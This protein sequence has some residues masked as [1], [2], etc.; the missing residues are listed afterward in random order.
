MTHEASY[1]PLLLAITLCLGVGVLS[2]AAAA[3]TIDHAGFFSRLENSCEGA[4]RR[5]REVAVKPCASGRNRSKERACRNRARRDY[6]RCRRNFAPRCERAQAQWL[7]DLSQTLSNATTSA[8]DA[9]RIFQACVN[10][11]AQDDSINQQLVRHCVRVE[12]NKAQAGGRPAM[13]ARPLIHIQCDP[14][15]RCPD[16]HSRIEALHHMM[17]CG[18]AS[19]DEDR[20]GD[21]CESVDYD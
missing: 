4:C 7:G 5:D 1:L 20:D 18:L 14:A 10:R 12:S 17:H 9:G 6:K 3:E 11:H 8:R 15:L 2:N 16:F 13:A 19:L 21:A